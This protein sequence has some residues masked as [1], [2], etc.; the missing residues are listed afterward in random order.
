MQTNDL[1]IHYDTIFNSINNGY[2][3]LQN[4]LKEHGRFVDTQRKGENKANDAMCAAVYEED[5]C[6]KYILAVCL[7]DEDNVL[8]FVAPIMRT[9][10]TE[11]ENWADVE[12]EDWDEND[13]Y[14]ISLRY[15]EVAYGF[16]L[17]NILEVIDEYVNE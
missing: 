8:I 3:A 16:T 11:I 2:S 14:W 13:G 6:E 15:S 7:D 9:W 1:S 10:H 17:I 5:L 4:F 12:K